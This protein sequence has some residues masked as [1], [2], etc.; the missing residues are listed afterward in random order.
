MHRGLP[1]INTM[2]VLLNDNQL[3][4]IFILALDQ[5]IPFY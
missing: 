3:T 2:L 4:I 1:G 5:V